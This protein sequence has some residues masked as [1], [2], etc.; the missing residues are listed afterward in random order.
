MVIRILTDTEINQTVFDE[1]MDL[2]NRIWPEGHF[3]HLRPEYL[4]GLFSKSFEGVFVA[5]DTEKDAL[6]GHF[7]VI[8]TD[9]N[10]IN[11]YFEIKNFTVLQ[12]KGFKKGDNIMYL[13][14]AI[15]N[16]EY[17]G[18]GCMK[19]LGIAFCKWLDEKEKQG[20]YV[21]DAY[22]EAVSKDGARV[23]SSGFGMC[24]MDDVDAKGI[25]HYRSPDGLTVYRNRIR[26]YY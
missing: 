10:N 11:D 19:Q 25:G 21:S 3:A 16:E 24:P 13:Y 14:T 12:N 7:Y 17:R 9:M 23:C 22:A 20:C 8:I 6:A 18:S 15:L 4:K 1:M 2:E 26:K 5:W